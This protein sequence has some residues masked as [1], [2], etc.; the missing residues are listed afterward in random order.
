MHTL[1]SVPLTWTNL[2]HPVEH[3]LIDPALRAVVTQRFDIRDSLLALKWVLPLVASCLGVL[4][5][6]VDLAWI[7]AVS[8]ESFDGSI[9]N[10]MDGSGT[11]SHGSYPVLLTSTRLIFI[12]EDPHEKF[13]HPIRRCAGLQLTELRQPTPLVFSRL[14]SPVFDVPC[15]DQSVLHFLLSGMGKSRE[16]SQQGFFSS[17]SNA[18]SSAS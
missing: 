17:L 14:A 2:P 6:L 10:V 9:D 4:E 11:Y 8:L 5:L 16:A 15:A 18:I 3:T 1:H 12:G 13:F 7:W